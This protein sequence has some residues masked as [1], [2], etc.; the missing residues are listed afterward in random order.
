M[1][2]GVISGVRKSLVQEKKRLIDLDGWLKFEQTYVEPVL[3][4]GV[5]LGESLYAHHKDSIELTIPFDE[6]REWRGLDGTAGL[7]YKVRKALNISKL[8][9]HVST[10][11]DSVY[12]S[13]TGSG[14]IAGK[15][16]YV[17]I[18]L[19]SQLPPSCHLEYEEKEVTEVKRVAKVVCN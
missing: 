4:K 15:D 8:R 17:T 6:N 16:V 12:N 10:Y 3:P 5:E 11:S 18:S 2:N 13:Y 7:I 14:C 19:G 1:T 9:R